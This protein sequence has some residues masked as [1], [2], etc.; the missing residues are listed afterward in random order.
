MRILSCSHIEGFRPEWCI[1]T[2]CHCRDTPFWSE[3]LYICIDVCVHTLMHTHTCTY[4]HTYT[5]THTHT[6]I[7]WM[8][9]H[10]MN[11]HTRTHT[12]IIWMHTLSDKILIVVPSHWTLTLN[13][14]VI[15]QWT[16]LFID[17]DLPALYFE[18]SYVI[19][20]DLFK[21]F[22]FIMFKN[23]QV[24]HKI[25]CIRSLFVTSL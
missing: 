23:V 14:A 22:W 3:T 15:W 10:K 5:H 12:H 8:H 24:C 11:A 19:I 6:H 20:C 16:F 9:T 13:G 7:R 21:C 17:M 18:S 25:V 1:C 4:K 2:I